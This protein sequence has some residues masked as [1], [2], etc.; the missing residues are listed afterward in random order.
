MAEESDNSG[1]F[2]VPSLQKLGERDCFETM[3]EKTEGF[4]SSAQ[5]LLLLLLLPVNTRELVS[6]L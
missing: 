3:A 1:S 2:V 5:G 6:P 4:P